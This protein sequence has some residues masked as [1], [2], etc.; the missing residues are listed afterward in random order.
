MQASPLSF[1]SEPARPSRR[2]SRT[3]G[4]CLEPPARVLSF[5]RR[6]LSI[7]IE[8]P[9]E[10]RGGC[11]RRVTVSPTAAAARPAVGRGGGRVLELVMS[12]WIRQRLHHS[13]CSNYGLPPVATARNTSS[14][15]RDQP[16]NHIAQSMQQLWTTTSGNGPSVLTWTSPSPTTYMTV[17]GSPAAKI[18]SPSAKNPRV[19]TRQT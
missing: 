9:A 7:A 19:I 3:P 11:K 1:V 4:R 12:R 10:G 14:I 6:S 17:P 15:I 16:L 8:T 18:G 2:P 13:P 5:C